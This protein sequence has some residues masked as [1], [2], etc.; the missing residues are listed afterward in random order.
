M[1]AGRT[2][3]GSTPIGRSR[4]PNCAKGC[5]KSIRRYGSSVRETPVDGA[6]LTAMLA[7]ALGKPAGDVAAQTERAAAGLLSG[8][9]PARPLT[10]LECA[11]LIDAVADPFHA[12][13]VDIY[14]NYKR[15]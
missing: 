12:A 14:G 2:R 11:L 13:E 10:R 9:D 4:N 15:K 1:S 6:L 7:E 8:Y 5:A 3:H